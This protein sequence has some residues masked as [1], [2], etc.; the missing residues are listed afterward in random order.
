MK[1]KC[2]ELRPNQSL[3]LNV[4]VENNIQQK[5]WNEK[6]NDNDENFCF[7]YLQNRL[8]C[9][10]LNKPHVNKSVKLHTIVKLYLY[11]IVYNVQ[12]QTYQFTVYHFI[13]SLNT[14]VSKLS[15]NKTI[16]F[17]FQNFLTSF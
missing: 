12:C 8:K 7:V 9:Q 5:P 1:V 14:N 17:F 16:T 3:A 4:L 6:S 10:T 15:F 13:E 2:F 11:I